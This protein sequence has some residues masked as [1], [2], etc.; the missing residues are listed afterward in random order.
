[1]LSTPRTKHTKATYFLAKDKDD[2]G[3]IE[4]KRGH[5]A[6]IRVDMNTQS[7]QGKAFQVDKSQLTSISIDCDNNKQE[8]RLP[9]FPT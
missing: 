8:K 1:M 9:R 3:E 2:Q 4:F 5:T 6:N 7:K